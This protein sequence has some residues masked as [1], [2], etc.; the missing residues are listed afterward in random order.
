MTG[1][2]A[3]SSAISRTAT[4][5][6]AGPTI[7]SQIV[8]RLTVAIQENS[9]KAQLSLRP[10]ELGRVMLEIRLHSNELHVKALVDTVH[11]KQAL[12]TS[13]PD[14]QATLRE[15]GLELNE[16]SVSVGHQNT[17]SGPRDTNWSSRKSKHEHR[18]TPV[19]KPHEEGAATVHA[20]WESWLGTAGV[21]CF[22]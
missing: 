4:A 5:R 8:Q 3:R 11:A 9:S 1:K 14:L 19:L 16:F 2:A 15:K 22:V 18:L 20:D 7:V 6:S 12:Q 17:D 10:P 21:D 13:L